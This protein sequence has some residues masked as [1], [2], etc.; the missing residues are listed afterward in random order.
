[1][2]TL[3]LRW[4]VA[5]SLTDDRLR[6]FA[7]A[8][9]RGGD[10][11]DGSVER[12]TD[13]Y[14]LGLPATDGIKRRGREGLLEHK[15][16]LAQTPIELALARGPVP[17][18]GVVERWVKTWPSASASAEGLAW[19]ELA[20]RRAT[21]RL[22]GPARAELTALTGPA[23][24]GPHWTLAV[25]TSDLTA[26]PRLLELAA[27]LLAREPDL[28]TALTGPDTLAESCG[29]PAWLTHQRPA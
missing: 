26:L 28:A 10:A 20:K 21:R 29:Y 22:S 14:Q 15:R 2:E 5:G 19:I 24:V 27:A 23:L 16:R 3:E 7:E 9:G 11:G 18:P 12:R 25:E 6:A 13:H 17:V 1:M 8:D 4:F